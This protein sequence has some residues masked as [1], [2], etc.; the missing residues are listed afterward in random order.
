[1]NTNE[2]IEDWRNVRDG[3]TVTIKWTAGRHTPCVDVYLG[4][5]WL[6]WTLLYGTPQS[7]AGTDSAVEARVCE[8]AGRAIRAA[9]AAAV[10]AA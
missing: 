7:M 8:I 2:P 4:G 5:S 3:Y 9:V 6:G 10:V 1:M